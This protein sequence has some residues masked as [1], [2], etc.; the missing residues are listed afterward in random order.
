M[1]KEVRDT[2]GLQAPGPEED[3]NADDDGGDMVMVM[4]M[5]VV[6]TRRRS[7]RGKSKAAS[8]PATHRPLVVAQLIVEPGYKPSLGSQNS[9]AVRKTRGGGAGGGW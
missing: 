6:M 9:L 4:L 7:R 1:L 8:H 3:D 5:T 2:A